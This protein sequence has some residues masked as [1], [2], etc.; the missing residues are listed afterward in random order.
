VN[1]VS[2][3]NVNDPVPTEKRDIGTILL[4]PFED[5]HYSNENKV[6]VIVTVIKESNT[7][8]SVIGWVLI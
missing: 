2:V 8:Y 4:S 5:G 6:T 1:K 7:W 3:R